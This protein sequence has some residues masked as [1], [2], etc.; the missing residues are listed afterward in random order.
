MANKKS[1]GSA[2]VKRGFFNGDSLS[3]L[4]FVIALIPISMVL[5]KINKG[6]Q[7]RKN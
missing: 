7:T 5:R 4:L 3:L 6:I 1:L 2:A